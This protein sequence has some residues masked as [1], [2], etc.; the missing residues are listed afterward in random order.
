[1]FY[2]NTLFFV[3]ENRKQKTI[4]WLST[5]FSYFSILE[6]RKPFSKTDAKQAYKVP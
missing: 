1:M 3:L 4:F 2:E 5:V 6:N